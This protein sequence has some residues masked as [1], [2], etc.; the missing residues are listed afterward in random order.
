MK[1]ACS[2]DEA[3]GSSLMCSSKMGQT[4]TTTRRTC[5]ATAC[6]AGRCGGVKP[7]RCPVRRSVRA[8]LCSTCLS[9]T[10]LLPQE[11]ILLCP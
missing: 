8:E 2:A 4:S 5:R 10:S 1:L 11:A 6:S 9:T 3:K 7:R